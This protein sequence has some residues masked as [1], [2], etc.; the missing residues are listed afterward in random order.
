MCFPLYLTVHIYVQ[1]YATVAY[2]VHMQGEEG[3]NGTAQTFDS[4]FAELKTTLWAR[5]CTELVAV[6][7]QN[8]TGQMS[9]LQEKTRLS[10]GIQRDAVTLNITSVLSTFF[11]VFL[12]IT[13][14]EIKKLVSY[15]DKW[16]AL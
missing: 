5:T 13:F 3:W 14:C 8:S 6:T 10:N 4:I 1:T 2:M 15:A 11:I 7:F 12:E 9:Y 16:Q